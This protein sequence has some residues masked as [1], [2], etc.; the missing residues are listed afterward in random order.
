MNNP[1]TRRPLRLLAVWGSFLVFVFAAMYLAVQL[2]RAAPALLGYDPN[3]RLSGWFQF[4]LALL[5]PLITFCLILYA[6]CVAWLLFSRLFFSRSEVSIVVFAGPTT[7]LERWLVYKIFPND[8][9]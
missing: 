7:P 5:G 6:G 4:A 2:I 3:H 1:S 8:K 9:L